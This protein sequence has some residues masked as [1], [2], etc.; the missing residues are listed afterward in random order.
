MDPGAPVGKRF[1]AQYSDAH[2]GIADHCSRSSCIIKLQMAHQ[3]IGQTLP[4]VRHYK[5]ALRELLVVWYFR[6]VTQVYISY[7]H[8]LFTKSG[9]GPQ[10]VS[11]GLFERN[12]GI[13][14]PWE[15]E[16]SHRG[17]RGRYVYGFTC[18]SER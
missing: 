9:A 8:F 11:Q 5:L 2:I 14:G 10:R 3:H 13:E 4:Y 6:L 7:G 12:Q 18:C 1:R 16:A 15:A 17:P